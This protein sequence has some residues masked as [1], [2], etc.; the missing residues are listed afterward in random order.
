MF[1]D[2]PAFASF[3]VSDIAKARFFFGRTLGIELVEQEMGSLGLQ[4]EGGRARAMIYPKP[5]H[6]PARYTVLNFEVNNIDQT[7]KELKGKGVA[8]ETYDTPE[9][10][11]NNQGIMVDEHMKIK[12]A[13]F[14]DPA[15]NILSVIEGGDTR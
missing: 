3:S 11:T 5:D 15:G 10:K 8:F 14:K 13:W 12:I 2:T 9:I 7:V 4:L 1:K 6:V